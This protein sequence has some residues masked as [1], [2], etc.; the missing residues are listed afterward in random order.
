MDV[1]DICQEINEHL[2]RRDEVTARNTLIKLLRDMKED[3]E[4]YP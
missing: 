2:N 4:S 3:G 1:F